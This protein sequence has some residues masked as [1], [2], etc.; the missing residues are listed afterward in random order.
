[1]RLITVIKTGDRSE[2]VTEGLRRVAEAQ[3]EKG[4]EAIVAGC[5]EI[6]LVLNS[7]MLDVPLILSTDVLAEATVKIARG[8]IQLR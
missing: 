7:S 2:V 6:P 8:E 1:M 4:A 3:V 5:T